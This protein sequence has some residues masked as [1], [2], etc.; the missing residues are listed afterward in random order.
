MGSGSQDEN[1]A[2]YPDNT[3]AKVPS[4]SYTLYL[5]LFIQPR[6]TK[7]QKISLLREGTERPFS[8]HKRKVKCCQRS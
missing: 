3:V 8:R 6:V 7:P 2:R 4:Y 5:M 1:E